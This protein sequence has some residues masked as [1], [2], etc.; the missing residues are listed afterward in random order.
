MKS[1]DFS[2]KFVYLTFDL[3]LLNVAITIVYSLNP[4]LELLN[5]SDRILYY[6]YANIAEII[7]YSVYSKR[8]YYFRDRFRNRMKHIS[9]R[10]TLFAV[11]LYILAQILLPSDYSNRIL[12]E[13]TILFY[14]LKLISFYFIYK[15][16][17]LRRQKGYSIHRVIILG[18]NDT[19]IILGDLLN[20]NPMLGLKVVGYIS[21]NDEY[22]KNDN[23]I[24]GKFDDLD[25]LAEKFQIDMIFVT[26][27]KYYEEDNTKALLARCNKLGLRVKYIP[28]NQLWYKARIKNMESVGSFVMYNPQEIPLDR[29]SYRFVKRF[30]DIV[31]SLLVIIF[32]FSWLFPIIIILIKLNSK[33][34]I[35]FIQERT[36][37]NN[38]TFKCLKFRTMKV[39]DEADKKQATENDD[40]ITSIGRFFRKTNIDELPQFFNVLLGDMSVVGPR[41]HMLKHTE[42][43]S[44]LIDFYKVRHFVKPGITGWAQVNG[45]RGITDE[46]W[47]ME[48]RVE[49]DMNYL[50]NWTYMWDL[51]IIFMTVAGKNVYK[52]AL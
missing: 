33:G 35:F 50:Q 26:L 14:G 51:K 24:L 12:I 10:M 3:V 6:L 52:N 15:F 39:N 36:G 45:Y 34:P 22:N 37:I 2:M 42:Q 9:K 44:A 23:K 21:E 38:K 49:Y 41:P 32:L 47:K 48:K 4:A 29:L 18:L 1:D 31:F 13:Y 5:T 20:N 16:L 25:S 46:L 28:V 7:A 27:P 11:I 30:F 43:Y 19:A 17:R 8:N 40:R